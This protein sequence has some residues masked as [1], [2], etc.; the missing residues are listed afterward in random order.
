[1]SA[2]TPQNPFF[3]FLSLQ[4]PQ[5]TDPQDENSVPKNWYDDF[6]KIYPDK[7]H[8]IH[9][10]MVTAIDV[11]VGR[12]MDALASSSILDR[13]VIIFLSESTSAA[14]KAS[15]GGGCNFPLRGGRDT[16]W[17]G[18]IRS[19]ALFYS[20]SIQAKGKVIDDMIHVTDWLPTLASV[21]KYDTS[22]LKDMSGVNIWPTLTENKQTKRT[23]MIH[24]IETPSGEVS[25]LRVHE[26]KLVVGQKLGSGSS[27][28]KE[29]VVTK[30]QTDALL[31]P[32][33]KPGI[34][35]NYS[36]VVLCDSGY[37]HPFLNI[38]APPCRPS[39][40]PCLFNIEWDPCEFHNLA[41]FMQRTVN[42]LATKLGEIKKVQ[43][44]K[45]PS[46]LI[47]SEYSN[48]D[49]YGGCW[50]WWEDDTND[51]AQLKQSSPTSPEITH[52]KS[53]TG[54]N[55]L[56]TNQE[57][58][59]H[60][61]GSILDKE[62][63]TLSDSNQNITLGEKGPEN[64]YFGILDNRHQTDTATQDENENLTASE[65]ESFWNLTHDTL[66]LTHYSELKNQTK[67]TKI[68]DDAENESNTAPTLPPSPPNLKDKQKEA[69]LSETTI[70]K[71][72]EGLSN[73]QSSKEADGIGLNGTDE[74]L[75]KND[76]NKANL[77]APGDDDKKV[78]QKA[79]VLEVFETPIDSDV[80]VFS[81]NYNGSDKPL[82]SENLTIT[83]DV[84]RAELP[85][86]VI[87]YKVATS[88][89][90]TMISGFD[91]NSTEAFLKT[92]AI[93]GNAY[94]EKSNQYVGDKQIV[95]IDDEKLKLI[96]QGGTTGQA[97]SLSDAVIDKINKNTSVEEFFIDWDL[98]SQQSKVVTEE[99]TPQTLPLNIPNKLVTFEP[100]VPKSG[101]VEPYVQ[102][103][104]KDD[105]IEN[106]LFQRSM[107]NKPKV[108][109][110]VLATSDADKKLSINEHKL[111]FSSEN[112]DG[113][114]IDDYKN[115]FPTITVPSYPQV[116]S[117]DLEEFKTHRE[118]IDI[119]TGEFGKNPIT[120]EKNK[121]FFEPNADF[122]DDMKSFNQIDDGKALPFHGSLYL[123]PSHVFN[124]KGTAKDVHVEE[125]GSND[126]KIIL[127][128]TNDDL[129]HFYGIKLLQPNAAQIN[130]TEITESESNLKYAPNATADTKDI[131]Y[132]AKALPEP[133]EFAEISKRVSKSNIPMSGEI[134]DV[135]ETTPP[136][137]MM[138]IVSMIN[139][140]ENPE[141]EMS[142]NDVSSSSVNI[143]E[144]EQSPTSKSITANVSDSAPSQATEVHINNTKPE[145][146]GLA[147]SK[148][149]QSTGTT[150]A[151]TIVAVVLS[152][153]VIIG[154][155]MIAIVA[156]ISKNFGRYPEETTPIPP[157]QETPK[158]VLSPSEPLSSSGDLSP[159]R[160]HRLNR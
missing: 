65:I 96:A 143:S 74:H 38:H 42:F 3:L 97:Y 125:Q 109:T 46:L 82:L 20:S 7:E 36:S 152:A 106:V 84:K 72:S 14:C 41:S 50:K 11:S 158:K 105:N 31:L 44:F 104:Q 137:E 155:A 115:A 94:D 85:K 71:E 144:S 29:R 153:F 83:G 70:L 53:N 4:L 35:K 142:I 150:T 146:K 10:A 61:L 51:T 33:F 124:F 75:R 15:Q 17:E 107:S 140:K 139:K 132:E 2:K 151:S 34:Q 108:N 26:Y 159:R 78:V 79:D 157:K 32:G 93:A 54:G 120:L 16:V 110:Y 6:S 114:F 103:E 119:H 160:I 12:I 129:S 9:A 13:S 113:H 112:D 28:N 43:D 117:P 76:E 56:K 116:T 57:F 88:R 134:G 5:K 8:R 121:V 148:I 131:I 22:K 80:S 40:E 95:S 52:S 91:S 101:I 19:T 18:G 27:W 92:K 59:H 156:L 45:K 123:G 122:Q 49:L 64:A 145:K 62:N 128:N 87:E 147:S 67:A 24:T 90:K 141:P 111:S 130:K 66:N 149:L 25:A 89:G 154:M 126:Q 21:A 118:H 68:K 37:P 47:P 55:S 102:D 73:T 100:L 63:T 138:K 77:V 81:I 48:P 136:D 135:S 58:T 98:L 23:F 127:S 133:S 1:M 69:G 39:H 99:P 86:N 60:S 30:N